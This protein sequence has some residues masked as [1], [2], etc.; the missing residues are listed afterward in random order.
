[1]IIKFNKK[2]KIPYTQ[3]QLQGFVYRL[4]RNIGYNEIHNLSPKLPR[5]FSFSQLFL[6]KDGYLTFVISS[7]FNELIKEISK[8]LKKDEIVRI[9]N[10]FLTILSVDLFK[11]QF[12]PPIII[13]TETPIIVRIP[14]KNFELYGIKLDKDIEYFYWRPKP[15]IPFEPFVKQLEARIYKQYKLFTGKEKIKEYPIFYKFIYKK[16]IDLPFYYKN[17]KISRPGTLWEFEINPNLPKSLI[18]FIIDVGLGELAS[19]GYGFVNLVK[20]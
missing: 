10:N 17:S 4:V 19:Q 14:K 13:K 2:E 3:N 12:K 16:T 20:N 8:S 7:P 6:A 18:N 11:P 9:G 1:M 15:G 5:F